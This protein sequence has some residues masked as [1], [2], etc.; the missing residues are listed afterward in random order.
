MW[1]AVSLAT[2]INVLLQDGRVD[3]ELNLKLG[4]VNH[5]LR[6]LLV[7]A[8][9]DIFGVIIMIWNT[10]LSCELLFVLN[11]DL[12]CTFDIR[13]PPIMVHSLER[14]LDLSIPIRE[15]NDRPLEEAHKIQGDALAHPQ[16]CQSPAIECKMNAQW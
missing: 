5:V 9:F 12:D 7:Q 15:S 10:I 13:L 11:S 3:V 4:T 8:Y 2:K 1:V 14:I 16:T 6:T